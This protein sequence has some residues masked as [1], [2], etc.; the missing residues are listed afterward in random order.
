MEARCRRQAQAQGPLVALFDTATPDDIHDLLMDWL[1]WIDEEG[2][3]PFLK[4]AN[5]IAEH[6]DG[7]C[8]YIHT[9]HTNARAEGLNRKIRVVTARAYGK[10]RR[11]CA[12]RS[13]RGCPRS[14]RRRGR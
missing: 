1:R 8:A 5:T 3:P 11:P 2:S 12:R 13:T 6:F 14:R 4:A 10:C 7:V 9:G